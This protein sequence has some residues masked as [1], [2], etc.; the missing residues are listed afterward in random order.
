MA[1][2][3]FRH[4]GDFR[5]GGY[6]KTVAQKPHDFKPVATHSLRDAILEADQNS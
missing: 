3:S 4:T 2:G 5:E 1:G 6:N